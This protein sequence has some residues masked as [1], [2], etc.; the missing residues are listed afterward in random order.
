MPPDPIRLRTLYLESTTAPSATSAT[1]QRLHDL[2]R[3]RRRDRAALPGGP[4]DR[5]RHSDLRMV[6]RRER[7][8]PRLVGRPADHLGG[9]RLA[10][11]LETRQRAGGAGPL[12]NHLGHHLAELGRRPAA[13]DLR[14]LAWIELLAH[15]PVGGDHAI[16]K[17][18][19]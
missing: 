7:D 18:R 14:A 3:D 19:L 12:L 5:D 15:G 17:P 16:D 4:L 8:E 9:T 2:L 13:H 10:G 6:D 1:E 11:H